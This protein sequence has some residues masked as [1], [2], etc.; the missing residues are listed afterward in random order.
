MQASYSALARAQEHMSDM[1]RER[2][3]LM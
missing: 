1:K 3:W 2:A